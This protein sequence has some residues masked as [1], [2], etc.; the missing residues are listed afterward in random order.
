[1]H[2]KPYHCPSSSCT[3]S[4]RSFK[5]QSGLDRHMQALHYCCHTCSRGF[6]TKSALNDVSTKA[7][8]NRYKLLTN[9]TEAQSNVF[10]TCVTDS[11]VMD[12]EAW[13]V[14][15]RPRRW[16]WHAFQASFHK[17]PNLPMFNF[18]GEIHLVDGSWLILL[19]VS[20]MIWIFT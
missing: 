7:I 10:C 6:I 4:R 2:R 8:L 12:R 11:E 3:G 14:G 20:I 16:R 5:H 9:I 1:M 13:N 17:S 19:Q 15:E 18:E